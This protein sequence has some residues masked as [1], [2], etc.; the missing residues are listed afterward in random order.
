[1][2]RPVYC[3]QTLSLV[4]SSIMSIH[5]LHTVTIGYLDNLVIIAWL[6]LQDTEGKT[7]PSV[8]VCVTMVTG[9]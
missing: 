6:Q 5:T 9:V 4:S 3:T 8:C 2:Y 1:M 7:L